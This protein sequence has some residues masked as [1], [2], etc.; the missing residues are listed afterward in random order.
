MKTR[1]KTNHTWFPKQ[2]SYKQ[3]RSKIHQECGEAEEQREPPIRTFYQAC[4]DNPDLKI[5]NRSFLILQ[6]TYSTSQLDNSN[7][8]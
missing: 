7:W 3:R 1:V 5:G 4:T 2:L 6:G 8:N